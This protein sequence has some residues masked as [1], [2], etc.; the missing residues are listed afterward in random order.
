MSDL[1]CRQDAIDACKSVADNINSP[2][3]QQIGAEYCLD[4]IKEI[5]SAKSEWNKGEWIDEK[6]NMYTRKVYC[7]ECGCMA[8]SKVKSEGDVYNPRYNIEFAKSNFCPNCG[9]D[10]RGD[11]WK[12]S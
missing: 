4:L 9:A 7:S 8:L 2:T 12:K 10:M 5:S 3:D 11:R 1:I 6:P